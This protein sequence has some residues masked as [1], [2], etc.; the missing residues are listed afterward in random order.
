M[1]LDYLAT[2]KSLIKE[3][4][5]IKEFFRIYRAVMKVEMLQQAL[6]SIESWYL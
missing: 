1:H 4:P 3:F 5:N 2:R 6:G